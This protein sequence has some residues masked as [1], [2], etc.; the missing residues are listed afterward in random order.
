VDRRVEGMR[1]RG[2]LSRVYEL[3][4]VLFGHVRST[5]LQK[6]CSLPSAARLV[7]WLPVMLRMPPE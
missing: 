4:V 6:R 7:A 5:G 2:W 3:A 1:F